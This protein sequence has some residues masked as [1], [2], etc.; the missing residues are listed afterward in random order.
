VNN[1]E[2]GNGAE[3]I[4]N[5]DRRLTIRSG[6]RLTVQPGGRLT[7]TGTLVNNAGTG[8]IVVESNANASGSVIQNSSGVQATV[9][10]YVSGAQWHIISSPVSGQSISGFLPGNI[11]YS[12]V[13]DYYALT[14]YY[15]KKETSTAGGWGAYYTTSTG[16]NLIA[17]KGYLAARSTDKSFINFAGNLN[18]ETISI[19]VT[20][21]G[22][23]WNAI[24]N[25]FAS[26]IGVRNG[27]G[28]SQNFLGVNSHKID[29]SYGAIYIYDPDVPGYRIINNVPAEADQLEWDYVQSGQ[30]FIV[31]SI[32]GGESISFTQE[33]RHHENG[34]V[35][36]S[37]GSQ[38]SK[39]KLRVD[40]DNKSANTLIA[41]NSNMTKG[42]DPTYD[43]GQFGSDVGFSLYTRL[44]E[45]DNG[46]N[47]AIQALPDYDLQEIVI[48]VGF[49]FSEGGEVTFSAGEIQLPGGVSAM[50]EDRQL[51][52]FTD[53]KEKNYTVTLDANSSGPGRFYVY[54]DIRITNTDDISMPEEGLLEIYS[55]GKEIHII[56]EIGNNSYA[57]LYD[58]MGRQV[59]VV[60]LE[61]G[62]RNSFMVDD[63]KRGIYLIRV[64]GEGAGSRKRLFIE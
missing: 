15:E 40:S 20:R 25:P 49:D 50:L 55:F 30:G 1:L 48:P 58:L 19:P 3:L 37:L 29:Q 59:K 16:G 45:M 21:L 9:Q 2:I 6:G 60:R 52:T 13:N 24:G 34:A 36:K 8:G 17:G 61:R 56:G 64:G 53:L 43:A 62:H 42:L 7:S 31:K 18:Y 63:F 5:S 38:W 39:I 23:G 41:F 54:L 28:S 51:G 11:S 12:A 32:E 57:T 33:M 47:F 10:R 4:V 35:M 46:V 26:A 44:V 27:A 22:N 14:H